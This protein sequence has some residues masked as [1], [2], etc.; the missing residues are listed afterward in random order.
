MS[1]IVLA[2]FNVLGFLFQNLLLFK[3]V[4]EQIIEDLSVEHFELGRFPGFL[5]DIAWGDHHW[6]QH[7]V[8]RDG[9]EDVRIKDATRHIEVDLVI[10]P[11]AYRKLSNQI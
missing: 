1:E 2:I 9:L 8:I 11:G 4:F 3:C 6:L 10:V 5:Q 7:L